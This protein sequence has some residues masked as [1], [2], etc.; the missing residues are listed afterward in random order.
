MSL[1]EFYKR[2]TGNF[3][4]Q[5]GLNR[6]TLGQQIKHDSD[7]IMDETWW[8]DPQSKVCYIYDYFHDDQ[9]DLK[10]HMTYEKTTK[11]R[12]DAKFI[13]KTHQSLDKDQVEYYLQFRPSQPV[14]FNQNDELYYFETEYRQ[15]YGIEFPIGCYVD[16]PDNKMVYRKWLICGKEI[17]DQFL[18]YLILPCTYQLMWIERDGSEIYKRKMWGVNKSQKSYTIGVYT[19]RYFTRPDNQTKA[20][21]PLNSITENIWYTEDDSKNMRFVISA[22]TKHPIVWKVTKVENSD[23]PGLQLLTFYQSYWDQSRDFIEYKDNDPSKQIIGMWADYF[24]QDEKLPPNKETLGTDPENQVISKYACEIKAS[25]P[26]IKVGGSYRLLTAIVFNDLRKDLTDTYSNNVFLWKAYI[27]DEDV[28][29][30]FTWLAQKDFNKIKLKAPND[31]SYLNKELTITCT[32]TE[33]I[34]GSL[35]LLLGS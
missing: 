17:A 4:I 2:T 22:K 5:N 35:K 11:T 30:K 28:S 1:Y 34:I 21:V 16:I 20:Y 32:I 33:K 13:V 24:L 12:I 6:P 27:N 19:D 18:K 3:Q 31:R 14:E 15:R 10:D 29:E 25:T 23:R 8:G 26:S 9:L 7:I